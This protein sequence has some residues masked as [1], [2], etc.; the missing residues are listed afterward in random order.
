M[1]INVNEQSQ[2]INISG[3]NMDDDDE[4]DQQNALINDKEEALLNIFDDSIDFI[5]N[6]EENANIVIPE[7]AGGALGTIPVTGLDPEYRDELEKLMDIDQDYEFKH[8]LCEPTEE[9]SLIK[10]DQDSQDEDDSPLLVFQHFDKFKASNWR[11]IKWINQDKKV[12][13]G[14][15]E[16]RSMEKIRHLTT[17]VMIKH[18]LQTAIWRFDNAEKLKEIERIKSKIAKGEKIKLII[19]SHEEKIRK[20][21]EKIIRKKFDNLEI[22]KDDDDDDEDVEIPDKQDEKDNDDN[23]DDSEQTEGDTP[24]SSDTS[25]DTLDSND[26]TD[27]QMMDKQKDSKKNKNKNKNKKTKKRSKKHKK[28]RKGGRKPIEKKVIE[29]D[30]GFAHQI[31]TDR[32]ILCIFCLS[33]FI[34]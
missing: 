6:P 19:T 10:D 34:Y 16:R 8:F 20:Q 1:N 13:R 32:G 33:K 2:T 30:N 22:K 15:L 23:D 24:E 18:G 26:D 4:N 14:F 29:L 3:L 25:D 9:E 12:C 17:G 11:Q 31:C 21:R 7:E 27:E 5:G 28:K